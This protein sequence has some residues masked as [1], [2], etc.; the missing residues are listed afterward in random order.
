MPPPLPSPGTTAYGG[1]VAIDGKL[2]LIPQSCPTCGIGSVQEDD[3][4]FVS[5]PNSF[6]I[7]SDVYNYYYLIESNEIMGELM[8]EKQGEQ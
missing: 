5:H 2:L 1:V 4:D 6:L 8:V 3:N 7:N